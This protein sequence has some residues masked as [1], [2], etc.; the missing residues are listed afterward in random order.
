MVA[1]L[2]AHARHA[3]LSPDVQ[4][5][6][7]ES[8]SPVW[9]LR[10]SADGTGVRGGLPDA[11]PAAPRPLIL[12][13]R[14]QESSGARF[15]AG[16]VGR[17]RAV[18]WGLRQAGLGRSAGNP[19]GLDA[20]GRLWHDLPGH[21]RVFSP[22][23]PE[24]PVSGAVCRLLLGAASAVPADGRPPGGSG[25]PRVRRAAL[26]DAGGP[27]GAGAAAGRGAGRFGPVRRPDPR[28]L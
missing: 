27:G 14:A 20:P 16:S 13:R 23:G 26:R 25:A 28:V 24:P 4:P 1:A 18:A 22:A 17:D 11:Y 6:A 2:P 7:P 19:A 8:E 9:P 21:L 15:F 10:H 12:S 3:I 5:S